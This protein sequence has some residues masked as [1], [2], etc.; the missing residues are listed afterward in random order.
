MKRVGNR[1]ITFVADDRRSINARQR[2]LH[3][4]HKPLDWWKEKLKGIEVFSS[5]DYV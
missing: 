3:V 2:E 4:T 1:V 5:H